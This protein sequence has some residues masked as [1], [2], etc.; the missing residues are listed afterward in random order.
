MQVMQF[1]LDS[2]DIDNLDTFEK[3]PVVVHVHL[4]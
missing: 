3:I 2:S 4:N 1:H